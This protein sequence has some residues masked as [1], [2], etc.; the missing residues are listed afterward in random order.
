MKAELMDKTKSEMAIQKE[1]QYGAHNYRP[2]PVVIGKG[3]VVYVLDAEGRRYYYFLSSYSA[4]NQGHNHP[5]IVNARTEQAKKL[6]LTSRAF[7]NDVLG[8]YEE[9]ITR[10]FGY[11][12]VLPMNTGAERVETA[13]KRARRWADEKKGNAKGA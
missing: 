1:E 4:L 11:D 3:E 7:Y 12:K 10:L 9:Y 13:I 6:S 8:E 5:K 2:V